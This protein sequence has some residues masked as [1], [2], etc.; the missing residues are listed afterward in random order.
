MIVLA[1]ISV[2]ELIDKITILEIKVENIVDFDKKDNVTRELRTLIGILQGLEGLPNLQSLSQ[3]LSMV[4]LEL[5]RIED[6]KR[7]CERNQS[8][9]EHFIHLARQVYIK[10]DVRAQI[11]REINMLCGSY[12]VEENS[13]KK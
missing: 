3:Q 13:Y 11:K 9:D 6:A 4:N 5:W 12:I 8:F 1:P 7:E 2:G 10:N